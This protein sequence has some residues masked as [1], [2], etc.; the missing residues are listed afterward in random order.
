MKKAIWI[1]AIFLLLIPVVGLADS[2]ENAENKI[3]LVDCSEIIVKQVPPISPTEV[4]GYSGF[5]EGDMCFYAENMAG[6]KFDANISV[7]YVDNDYGV[8]FGQAYEFKNIS[9]T[10]WYDNWTCNPWNETLGNK[11]LIIY[12]NCT[13]TPYS[14][15][16]FWW[17]WKKT[18]KVNDYSETNPKARFSNLI[19]IGN[20]D[21]KFFKIETHRPAGYTVPNM[22]F[23]IRVNDNEL[24]SSSW[25]NTSFNFCRN[26]TINSSRVDADLTNFALMIHLNSSRID[27]TKSAPNNIAIVNSSCN[28]GGFAQPHEVETW[29]ESGDS[30]IWA[31]IPNVSSSSDDIFSI[32]YN[33]SNAQQINNVWRTNARFVHH[34]NGSSLDSTSNSNDCTSNN[35]VSLGVNAKIGKGA[36]F[37]GNQDLNCGNDSSL[38]LTSNLTFY[39]WVNWAGATGSSPQSGAIAKYYQDLGAN[40]TG[41]AGGAKMWVHDGAWAS[42]NPGSTDVTDGSWYQI[43]GVRDNTM[44]RIHV[45]GVEEANNSVGT[46]TSTDIYLTYI[47][48]SNGDIYT[49]GTWNG[50]LDEARIYAEALS[51]AEIKAS[52]YSESDDLITLFGAEQSQAPANDNPDKPTLNSPANDSTQTSA[53]VTLNFTVTD[54]DGDNVTYELYGDSNT[55]PT[56]QLQ[57][58]TE[59]NGTTVTYSWA[60]GG[61]HGDT[62]YWKVNVSD[63]SSLTNESDVRQFDLCIASW[64]CTDFGICDSGHDMSCLAVTDA[65]SCGTS[66]TGSLSTYDEV[67][68]PGAEG[69]GGG[70][71]GTSSSNTNVLET[72]ETGVEIMASGDLQGGMDY[73]KDKLFTEVNIPTSQIYGGFS[74]VKV[75]LIVLIIAGAI[76]LFAIIKGRRFK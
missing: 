27:Y 46:P 44:L 51:H 49:E 13:N 5:T 11:S 54:P 73:I 22:P 19:R 35:S 2:S 74:D 61:S 37:A 10:V 55:N 4:E 33:G 63:P 23:W 28:N 62:F 17:D 57:T 64:S 69:S 40:W 12:Q 66:F 45:N 65:N 16:E 47:G 14:Q 6:A 7:E 9:H 38:D 26:I 3:T 25:W 21:G 1:L 34:L 56:T 30:Y 24:Y 43:V 70:G 53:T 15:E 68:D 48:Y 39:A 8:T 29:N 59:T 60:T 41:D 75:P 31:N 50:T 42:S 18:N 58:A 72:I 36:N 71:G 52:Y 67:C 76:L 20:N 32:Y